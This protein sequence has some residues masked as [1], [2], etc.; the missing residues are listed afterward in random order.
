MVFLS[1]SIRQYT[2]VLIREGSRVLLGLKKRGFGAG[3]WNGFGGK[4]QENERIEAAAKREV[5]EECGLAVLDL[6]KLAV[7]TFEFVG[8]PILMEVHVF[9]TKNFSGNLIESDGDYAKNLIFVKPMQLRFILPKYL[10]K[11]DMHS[12]YMKTQKFF[13]SVGS[14]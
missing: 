14:N 3:K 1:K 9:T 2:L 5:K 11:F 6:S 13:Q 4:V 10:H 12:E 8:D 7:I